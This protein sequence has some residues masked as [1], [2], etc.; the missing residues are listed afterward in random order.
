M[1]L[2]R[3]LL[4][5]VGLIITPTL[6]LASQPTIV[7][8]PT[9]V[10]AC[11]SGQVTFTVTANNAVSY[12]WQVRTSPTGLFTSLSEAPPYSGTNTATLTITNPTTGMNGYRFR[13]IAIGTPSNLTATSNAGLLTVNSVPTAPVISASGPTTICAPGSVT[14][15]GNTGGLG[16]WNNNS[17]A[18]NLTVTQSGT[19]FVTRTNV[20]GT[21]SSNSIVVTVNPQPTAA[22]IS[23]IGTTQICGNGS[24]TLSGNVNGTWNNSSTSASITVSSNGSFFVTNS[25]NCGT[26]TSNVISVSV[27][28]IPAAP[29]VSPPSPYCQFSAASPLSATG[30]NLRWYTVPSGG[31]ASTTPITPS[32]SPHGTFT[33]YVASSM[34]SCESARVPIQVEVKPQPAAPTLQVAQG[35]ENPFCFGGSTT[36]TASPSTSILWSTGETTASITT[37]SAAQFSATYVSATS[38]CTSAPGTLSVVKKPALTAAISGALTG[39][40][41]TTTLTATENVGYPAAVAYQWIRPDNQSVLGLSQVFSTNGLYQLNVIPADGCPSVQTTATINL[42]NVATPTISGQ[43]GLCP[44]GTATLQASASSVVWSTNA[45]T[46]SI[47]VSNAGSYTVTAQQNGCTATSLPFVV[48]NIPGPVAPAISASGGLSI[49][50][51]QTVTLSGNTNGTW[52]NGATTSTISVGSAGNYSV[53]V[54]NSCGSSVSNTLSVIQLSSPA[55]PQISGAS[56]FCPASSTTLVASNGQ[57]G[58]TYNWSAG[59]QGNAS[60]P[61]TAA[62]TYSVTAINSSGCTSSNSVVIPTCPPLPTSQLRAIDCGKMDLSLTVQVA[63]VPVVGANLYEFRI[64]DAN[65]NLYATRTSSSVVISGG[66]VVPN[67]QYSQTYKVSVRVRVGNVFGPFGQECLIGLMPAPTPGTIGTT[68]LRPAFCNATLSLNTS[69]SYNGVAMQSG[70]QA[71]FVPAGG[72]NTIIYS[73]GLNYF[74]LSMVPGLVAGQ[75]YSVS[76]R[77]KVDNT[78]GNYGTACNVTIAAPTGARMAESNAFNEA[79]IESGEAPEAKTLHMS[80]YPNPA[81]RHVNLVLDSPEAGRHQWEMMDLSGRKVLMGQA[82]HAQ[83]QI[84]SLDGLPRGVY[85]MRMVSPM[86][87]ITTQ[88]LMVE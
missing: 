42:T 45:T 79:V 81:H 57:Q 27:T 5:F 30:S 23:A 39:C 32:T 48:S 13:C 9:N 28:Q 43:T 41:P 44:N 86:G 26:V 46:S 17:T 37:T 50:T 65:N 73:T 53:T 2:F 58:I 71:R 25:N 69:V 10:S 11:A 1:K 35:S 76:I 40:G 16:V 7:S 33:F 88:K 55:Q 56:G 84:V 63:C 60:Y 51:G 38:G 68:M 52:S 54:S 64:L 19:Y 87:S 62:G 12:Q 22:V 24:V 78:W 70:Y 18:S 59:P 21:A 61:I 80:V 66:T 82:V 4:A 83:L 72:G 85:F 14:L 36:L 15:S 75:T 49:C 31:T 74:S 3:R 34:V 77:A 47:S 8:S 20:C 6:G 67:L 29:V